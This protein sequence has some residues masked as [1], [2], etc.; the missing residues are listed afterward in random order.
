MAGSTSI[1]AAIGLQLIA[2]GA[3]TDRGVVT[4]EAAID[5]DTFFSEFDA[6]C[7]APDPLTPLVQITNARIV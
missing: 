2:R 3:V 5:A 4:A 7:N 6:Y 1:P